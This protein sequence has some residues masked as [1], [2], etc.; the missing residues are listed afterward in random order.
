MLDGIGCTED[1]CIF[2]RQ[3]RNGIRRTRCADDRM[4]PMTERRE[5]EGEEP[6]SYASNKANSA[7]RINGTA[8]RRGMQCRSSDHLTSFIDSN[9]ETRTRERGQSKL[10]IPDISREVER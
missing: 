7:K 5:K 8:A 9:T 10:E 4:S 6:L 2:W 1:K 3:I